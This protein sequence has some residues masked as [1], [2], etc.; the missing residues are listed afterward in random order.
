MH[1]EKRYH[2]YFWKI[3][4]LPQLAELGIRT[5]Y[6]WKS[7]CKIRKNTNIGFPDNLA[8]F[9]YFLWSISIR[10][11]FVRYHEPALFVG[12]PPT[13]QKPGWKSK[14]PSLE[15][16]LCFWGVGCKPTKSAGPSK[17]QLFFLMSIVHKKY[18]KPSRSQGKPLFVISKKVNLPGPPG[19]YLSRHLAQPGFDLFW[20]WGVL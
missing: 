3:C 6:Q 11:N 9:R 18:L 4:T 1:T 12:L 8:G 10:K 7:Y 14:F 5:R 16:Q 20:G 13:P 17:W 19:Y 15:I 2:Q